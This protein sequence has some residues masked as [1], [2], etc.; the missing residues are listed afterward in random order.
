MSQIDA[1][2]FYALQAE[3]E[4]LRAELKKQG[5]ISISTGERT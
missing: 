1:E 3:N 2:T 4:K 5:G